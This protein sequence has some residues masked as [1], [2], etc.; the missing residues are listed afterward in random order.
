VE[1]LVN[2]FAHQRFEP[3]GMTTNREIPFAKSLVD[4]IFRFLGMEFIEGFREL[5]APQRSNGSSPPKAVEAAAAGSAGGRLEIDADYEDDDGAAPEAG[6]GR[7]RHEAHS[8]PQRSGRR[9]SPQIQ[10]EATSVMTRSAT[11]S[12]ALDSA[13]DAP[14]CDNCGTIT[15]RSGTCYKC[16]NCGNSMGCS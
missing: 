5:N 11:L 16:L 7:L 2:K 1:S 9:S 13:G 8:S 10:I 3:A 14:P 15:V 6:A 4:Y 12:L